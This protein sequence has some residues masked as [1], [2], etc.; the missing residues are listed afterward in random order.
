MLTNSQKERRR[1]H[2][3]T[4]VVF[5]V[6]IGVGGEDGMGKLVKSKKFQEMNIAFALDEGLASG[7]GD[8]ETR[9]HAY[10]ASQVPVFYGERAIW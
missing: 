4:S 5:S 10:S 6:I 2:H 8:G 1:C 3:L 7:G 9:D